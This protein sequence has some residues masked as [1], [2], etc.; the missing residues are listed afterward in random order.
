M[1]ECSVYQLDTWCHY[2]VFV[3][4]PNQHTQL[5]SF[6]LSSTF[7]ACLWIITRLRF[8]PTRYQPL[9]S[10]PK[11]SPQ[12]SEPP[13]APSLAPSPT[14]PYFTLSSH[15]QAARFGS[16][17]GVSCLSISLS[18]SPSLHPAVASAAATVVPACP[19]NGAWKQA[20]MAVLCPGGVH[21]LSRAL[22]PASQ[23]AGPPRPYCAPLEPLSLNGGKKERKNKRKWKKERRERRRWPG[24]K[25]NNVTSF[26]L[27]SSGCACWS[28]SGWRHPPPSLVTYSAV[29][30][31]S[32][33][34][35]RNRF[36]YFTKAGWIA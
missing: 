9:T 32:S 4:I 5:H 35:M 15:S 19:G 17:P 28:L 16:R 31:L 23:R 27:S 25:A 20:R 6:H 21:Y 36:K 7:P 1:P 8:I 26:V 24:T 3:T 14:Y 34:E 10:Q 33:P 11:A 2:T 12:L 22:P 30:F 29:S 13:D 18:F